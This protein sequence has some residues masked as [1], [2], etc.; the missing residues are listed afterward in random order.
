MRKGI[1]VGA[2]EFASLMTRIGEDDVVIAA[3]GGLLYLLNAGIVPQVFVGDEDSLFENKEELIRLLNEVTGESINPEDISIGREFL[4]RLGIAECVIL[5]S[6][7]DDTDMALAISYA[8]NRECTELEIYGGL[9]GRM[10]HSFANIQLISALSDEGVRAVM[11]GR[12]SLMTV[13]K[14]RGMAFPKEAAGYISVFS[15]EEESRG[16]TIRGLKYELTD[17]VLSKS[18]PMGVSNEFTGS[19]SYISVRDGKLLIIIP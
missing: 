4:E 11:Y 6:E 15:L 1:I 3:D 2:G 12:S 14:N 19:E 13:L 18:R 17:A 8:L 16:V 10:D 5:P 7:K 9:G